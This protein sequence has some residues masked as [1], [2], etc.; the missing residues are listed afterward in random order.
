MVKIVICSDWKRFNRGML[1]FEGSRPQAILGATLQTG[2]VVYL[3]P[4]LL[5]AQRDPS[6]ALKH[7][8]CHALLYQNTTLI[9]SFRLA[10]VPWLMEGLAVSYGNGGDYLSAG[11]WK[12][13]AVR[14]GYLFPVQSD[15]HIDRLPVSIGAPFMLSEYRFFIEFLVS[16]FGQ[17]RL[18]AYVNSLLSSAAKPEQAF[19]EQYGITLAQADRLFGEAVRT[20][21]WSVPLPAQTEKEGSSY[22]VPFEKISFKAVP[23]SGY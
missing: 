13:L 4:L 20:G 18:H 12:D 2:D 19:S 9:N 7:E 10:R 23:S 21:G 5:D 1:T 3:S 11:R 8:L 14:D 17:E 22:T 6:R 15:P 16:R